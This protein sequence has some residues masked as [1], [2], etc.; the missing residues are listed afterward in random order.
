MR[1]LIATLMVAA[2]LLVPLQAQRGGRGG[3]GGQGGGAGA[4]SKA[5]A[6]VDLSGYW[7]SVVTE[8]WRFRMVTPRKGDH[9]SVPLNGE[10][11]RV[12]DASYSK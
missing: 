3:R 7:V 8:D 9:P 10:G 4:T 5:A 12:A 11:A 2:V 1:H 6:P